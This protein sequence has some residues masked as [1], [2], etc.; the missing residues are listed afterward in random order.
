[1]AAKLISTDN[2][3]LIIQALADN[4]VIIMPCDTIY[5]FVGAAPQTHSRIADLKKRKE[6][7]FLQLIPNSDISSFSP[8]VLPQKLKDFWPAP[9]TLIVHDFLGDTVALRYPNDPLLRRVL[10][11]IGRPLYSTSVN[12]S[13]EPPLN[14]VAE[15]VEAFGD[16]VSLIVDGGSLEAKAPSTVVDLTQNPPEMVREGAVASFVVRALLE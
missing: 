8:D 15:I 3:D 5:G 7:R 12:I 6:K 4:E 16:S 2:F 13:G 1:M 9:L 10:T 11:A 14:S